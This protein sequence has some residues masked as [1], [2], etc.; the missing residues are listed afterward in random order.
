MLIDRVL[1][2]SNPNYHAGNLV[3]V[4]LH[5]DTVRGAVPSCESVELGRDDRGVASWP[6][7]RTEGIGHLTLW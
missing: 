6:E 7:A 3:I 5:G 1:A 2:I 4:M